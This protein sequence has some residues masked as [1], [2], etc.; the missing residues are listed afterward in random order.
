M[1]LITTSLKT[2]E[3]KTYHLCVTILFQNLEY[4]WHATFIEEYFF[5]PDYNKIEPPVKRREY[6]IWS[7][8]ARWSEDLK[9][10]QK[11]KM[12]K[13]ANNYFDET[14]KRWQNSELVF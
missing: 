5:S 10:S 4:E 12:K 1:D 11:R 3:T 8:D 6:S 2:V 14:F 13:M 9:S 7:N